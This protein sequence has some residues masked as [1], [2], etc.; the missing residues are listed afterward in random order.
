MT[1]NLFDILL[2]DFEDVVKSSKRA[3]E[4]CKY[5]LPCQGTSCEQYIQGLDLFNK[6]E[7]THEWQYTCMDL[8]H[9][10]CDALKNTPCKDCIKNNYR[11]FQYKH[12]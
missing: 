6:K 1:N 8:K 9:G 2:N 7:C 11:N 10:T 5:Y 12:F 4:F 3:C